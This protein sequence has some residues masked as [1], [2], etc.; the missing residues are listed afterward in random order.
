[1]NYSSGEK[2]LKQPKNGSYFDFIDGIRF[3]AVFLVVAFH[4][5]P[6]IVAGGYVGVDVFFV[7][8]GFLITRLVIAERFGYASFLLA[9]CRRILPAYLFFMIL[10][11]ILVVIT[12]LPLDV[13]LF[14]STIV[15]SSL[16]LQNFVFWKLTDYFSPT[17]ETNPFVHTWSL[18]VEWQFYLVF[19]LIVRPF[20]A[21][22]KRLVIVLTF[23]FLTTLLVST[24]GAVYKPTPTFY[25]M[26]FRI[27]EFLVG[28]AVAT[29]VISANKASG[30][31]SLT[32]F[33]LII[34]SSLT[35][36]GTTYFPGA[37]A[38]LPCVGTAMILA[39]GLMSPNNFVARGLSLFP[40]RIVGQAS[41]SIYLAH[42]PIIAF[43]NYFYGTP[44]TISASIALGILSVLA[45]L[46]SWR[47]IERPFRKPSTD[48]SPLSYR[49][50]LVVASSVVLFSLGIAALIEDG[51][52]GRFDNRVMTI[53]MASTDTGNFRSC[54]ANEP[55]TEW[56]KSP[57]RFGDPEVA[58]RVVLWGDSE[59]AALADGLDAWGHRNKI[60][61]VFIGTD[62][63]PPLPGME[64]QFRSA[65]PRCRQIQSAIPKLL[66]AHKP[67]LLI[68]H[69]SW[70]GYRRTNP[71]RF[72]ETIRKEFSNFKDLAGLVLVIGP[73]P[74]AR[75]NVPLAMARQV[76]YGI[77]VPIALSDSDFDYVLIVGKIVKENADANA[78]R[79]LDLIPSLCQPQ[80]ITSF[81]GLPA[82]FDKGHITSRVSRQIIE[83][84][85]E[86]L[87]FSH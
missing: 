29:L 65:L 34:F 1:V 18:A 62:A 52:P 25:L 66:Q 84:H 10:T 85:A 24:W 11:T 86:A 46:A 81:D 79:Y 23:L 19:P 71:K 35:Y 12:F 26:P 39:G 43:S 49:P 59:A 74:G 20:I 6:N 14:S 50:A 77:T 30:A 2:L 17:M 63:C 36:D 58:P 82:Y 69:A 9:R 73:M 70:I 41:Y 33:I 76:A 32:G 13:R 54:L 61:G 15:S 60:S 72:D 27:W 3:V 40:I 56:D 57:C 8:S 53:E 55:P 4:I 44:R 31:V 48:R 28:S 5:A 87:E 51:F 80:C 21:Q 83:Q 38:L 22:R 75:T 64:G 78:L 7:I 37:T 42:W 68:L 45:G 67:D 16:F 47:W